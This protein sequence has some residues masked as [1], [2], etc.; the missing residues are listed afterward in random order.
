MAFVHP[1]ARSYWKGNVQIFGL[2]CFIPTLD[3]V[4]RKESCL[5]SVAGMIDK[6]DISIELLR[7]FALYWLYISMVSVISLMVLS[8]CQPYHCM[9][10]IWHFRQECLPGI[11]TN[12]NATED[13]KKKGISTFGSNNWWWRQ[14]FNDRA[15][16]H[17]RHNHRPKSQIKSVFA[18]GHRV[19]TSQG[20]RL[21]RRIESRA[22]QAQY[23]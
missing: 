22:K 10:S 2:R 13:E 15:C 11:Q 16:L 21:H 9:S 5:F 6:S 12:W 19:T 14:T 3:S 23:V 18:D 17:T 7:I 4:G 1:C 20:L 8:T